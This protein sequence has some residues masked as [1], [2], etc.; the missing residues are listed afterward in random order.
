MA[1]R[2]R[3]FGRYISASKFKS[4]ILI[5]SIASTTYGAV[6]K[7]IQYL[8]DRSEQP[9]PQVL[10]VLYTYPMDNDTIVE[11]FHAKIREIKQKHS[12]RQ[13]TILPDQK[14]V[15][16]T[17][18]RLVAVIDAI[19]SMPGVLLPWKRMVE[20]CQQEG[21]WTIIDAAHAIGQEVG[22]LLLL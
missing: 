18:N 7:T 22:F 14:N 17:G 1:R 16:K 20:I 3:Y 19:S 2:R 5:R 11:A 6:A 8:G 13:F 4:R 21:V 9:R 10:D 15:S 12:D